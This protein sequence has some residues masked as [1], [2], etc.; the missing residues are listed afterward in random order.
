VFILLFFEEERKNNVGESTLSFFLL[1]ST[2][3]E[4]TDV[5]Q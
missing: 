2:T 4:K 5:D 3:L 1:E